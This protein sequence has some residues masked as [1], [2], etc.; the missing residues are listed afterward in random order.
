M[1]VAMKLILTQA[2]VNVGPQECLSPL[3]KERLI[4]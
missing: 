2:L 1:E 3:E 4:K